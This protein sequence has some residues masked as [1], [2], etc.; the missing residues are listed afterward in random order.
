MKKILFLITTIL[1][2]SLTACMDH[3]TD[4]NGS[5][6]S[7]STFT[8]QDKLDEGS[9]SSRGGSSMT[10]C[11]GGTTHS[12]M[13]EEIDCGSMTMSY[14]IFSGI[15]KI[16]VSDMSEG[17]TL[18]LTITSTLTS[19]NLEIVIIDPSDTI[20][21]TINVGETVTYTIETTISGEYFVL[22]GGESAE[23]DIEIDR[24]TS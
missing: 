7:L 2:F 15:S 22:I 21:T 1:L 5:D 19:G 4:D 14:S 16:H 10:T 3:I 8:I 6:T 17:D 20:L 12:M 23:F 24:T 9:F 11:S 13:Y 18:S